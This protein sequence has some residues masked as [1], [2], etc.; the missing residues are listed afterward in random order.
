MSASG[1]SAVS[2]D[3]LLPTTISKITSSS[4]LLIASKDL[5]S[6]MSHN[7]NLNSDSLTGWFF[8]LHF[9]STLIVSSPDCSHVKTLVKANG[10]EFMDCSTC[11]IMAISW[12]SS[13]LSV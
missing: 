10:L 1:T 6:P 2:L 5:E 8:C 9:Q 4:N 12:K 7:M 3:G 13:V 11:A